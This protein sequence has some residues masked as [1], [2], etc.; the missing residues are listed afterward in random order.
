MSESDYPAGAFHDDD[1][2]F[3]E[4]LK[5][6]R[7]RMRRSAFKRY[8]FKCMG[9]LTNYSSTQK[10]PPPGIKWKD[11]HVCEPIPIPDE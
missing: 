1:A 10:E 3:N 8:K 9:C 11:G 4:G 6:K 5:R 7:P 2:P